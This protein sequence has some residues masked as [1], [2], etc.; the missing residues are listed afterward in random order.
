VA[1]IAAC[2]VMG[3]VFDVY[4][5]LLGA[6]DALLVGA[7]VGAGVAFGMRDAAA[8]WTE[9]ALSVASGAAALVLVEGAS[10]L[11]L[12]PAPAFPSWAGPTLLLSDALRA[13]RATGFSTTQAGITTCAAIYGGNNNGPPVT[14][15]ATWE[16]RAGA[17]QWI[18]HLGDSMVYGSAAD[19]RFT[20]ELNRMEPDV[21]HV[22]AAIQGTA[23]DVYLTLARLFIARHE[24]TAV[25]MH[26]T[27]NDFWGV[28]EPQYPCSDWKS[29]LVYAPSGTRLRFPTAHPYD[30]S[31]SRL[32]WLM[33]NSPPPYALRATLRYSAF[34]AH[35]AAAL[36]HIGRRLGYA[37]ADVGDEVREAHLEAILRDARDELNARHIPLVVDIFH[38]RQTLES[39]EPSD[40]SDNIV[41][42]HIAERL[43]II[44]I[45]TW[46]PLRDALGHGVQPFT[47]AGGPT[48]S[49]FNAA[50]HV[51]IAQWLHEALPQAIDRARSAGA[52]R[53]G[54]TRALT[55]IA[56]SD[57]DDA[58]VTSSPETAA[59]RFRRCE[60]ALRGSAA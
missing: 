32:A 8:D 43:G 36:V 37:A 55:A 34:S 13:T 18:L 12:P 5:Q 45:D 9:I 48:D 58:V 6:W 41:M 25:V 11:W 42:K 59:Q 51:R 22:N 26:L 49:H 53:V 24:F 14:A 21:E 52:N 2:A 50:G 33:Q 57:Q 20:D 47:N 16:P 19:G 28:D 38:E 39:N 4:T 23:P 60:P 1:V 10:R 31:R 17:H 40:P 3:L 54:C 7:M 44:T 27:P 30:L 15:P 35:A 46:P 56:P 29:L